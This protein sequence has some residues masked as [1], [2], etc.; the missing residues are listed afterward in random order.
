MDLQLISL[1]PL[2]YFSLS[3]IGGVFSAEII[4]YVVDAS[5]P[6]SSKLSSGCRQ[7]FAALPHCYFFPQ[8]L[9]ITPQ[10][11]LIF[12]MMQKKSHLLQGN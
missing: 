8:D 11:A 7:M 6:A 2:G 4:S 9:S 10:I 12:F 3:E 1:D 5:L